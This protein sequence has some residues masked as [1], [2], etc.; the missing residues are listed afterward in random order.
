M[1]RV[2]RVRQALLAAG[3]EDSIAEFPAGTHSA[4]DAAAAV[5]CSVAQIAKSIVFRAGEDVI[6]V[7]ASGAHRIDRNKVAA[8][9]GLAVKTA[10]AAWVMSNTGFAVGGV[11]PVGHDCHVTTVID[12]ALLSLDPLWAA[13]GSPMHAFRT[14]AEQLIRLTNGMIAEVRQTEAVGT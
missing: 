6:L 1:D 14:S 10:D 5:G 4:A 13:A 11:A 8:A 2:D 9:V 7:V 3:H 12:S